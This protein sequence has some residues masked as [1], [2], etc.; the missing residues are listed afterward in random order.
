MAHRFK[1]FLIAILAFAAAAAVVDGRVCRSCCEQPCG[2]SEPVLAPT[3]GTCSTSLCG[4]KSESCGLPN[5]PAFAGCEDRPACPAWVC[6]L[7]RCDDRIP[8]DRD[9]IPTEPKSKAEGKAGPEPRPH[10]RLALQ[11]EASTAPPHEPPVTMQRLS[12]LC[13]WRL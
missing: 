10:W 6:L 8:A 1:M 12:R 9:R 5:A 3:C 2:T 13:I 4:S 7:C 11:P